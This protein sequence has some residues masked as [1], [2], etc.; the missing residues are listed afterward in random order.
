MTS[1][2]FPH[3][4]SAGASVVLG[5]LAGCARET[6]PAPPVPAVYV[7]TV[8]NDSGAASRLLSGS[9]RPR[10]E[11]ELAFR[12]GGRVMAR[13]VD[14]G[15]T[16]RAGQVLA[17]LDPAD[18]QLGVGAAAEQLRAAE[19]DAAQ[20]ASDAARRRGG[21]PAAPRRSTSWTCSAAGPPMRC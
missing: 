15:E 7:S 8:R 10:V 21:G 2:L 11:S 1:T 4:A 5:L 14:V 3:A 18:L 13:Q 19:V 6:P 9:V 12:T 16:V 20:T 17:R